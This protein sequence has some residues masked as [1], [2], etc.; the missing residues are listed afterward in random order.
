[1]FCFGD[2]LFRLFSK[3]IEGHDLKDT[4]SY[5]S[6]KM[7]IFRERATSQDIQH[8]KWNRNEQR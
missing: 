6:G 2:T 4:V 1:M 3:K 7:L 8:H 5:D